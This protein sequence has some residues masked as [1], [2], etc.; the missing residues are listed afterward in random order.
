MTNFT[1][2]QLNEAKQ[3]AEELYKSLGEVYCPYFKEKI[4]F[5]TRGLEHLN[6]KRRGWSRKIE[7]KYM[8]HK[9]FYLAPQILNKSNTL[10]GIRETK[11]FERVRVNGRTDT[12]LKFVTYY[13]FISVIDRNR[14]KIIVKQIDADQ[15]F[16]WS[17]IPFWRMDKSTMTRLL[18]DDSPEED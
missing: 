5:N 18:Y 13:E 17:I 10:Q 7:D 8:R 9:L 4:L 1:D 15:K 14:V 16:Y 12:M 2:E 3:K 11:G 6:Y